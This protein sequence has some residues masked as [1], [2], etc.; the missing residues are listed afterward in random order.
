MT[1]CQETGVGRAGVVRGELGV[2]EIEVL[3]GDR[4]KDSRQLKRRLRS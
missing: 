1:M 2:E 4:S 3:N